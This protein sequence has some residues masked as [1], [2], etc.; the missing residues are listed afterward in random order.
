M[1][2]NIQLTLGALSISVETP[3]EVKAAVHTLKRNLKLAIEAVETNFVIMMEDDDWYHE[4]YLRTMFSYCGI[5]DIVGE[6][7]TIYYHVPTSQ[8]YS[9]RNNLHASLCQTAFS[10]RYFSAIHALCQKDDSHFVDLH[11]W[12]NHDI[13]ERALFEKEN[14]LCVG[15]K[16]LPGRQGVTAG[17]RLDNRCWVKD[18][19]YKI[20]KELLGHDHSKYNRWCSDNSS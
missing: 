3:G 8:Y 14:P 11:L 5:A 12:K 4:Y 6:R 1:T 13:G 15:L 18:P 2:E 20:F 17:H 19:E 10:S 7:P 9:N 16:G